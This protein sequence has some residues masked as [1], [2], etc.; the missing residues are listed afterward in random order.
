MMLFSSIDFFYHMHAWTLVVFITLLPFCNNPWRELLLWM[1]YIYCYLLVVPLHRSFSMHGTLLHSTNCL[2]PS[3][4]VS[5]SFS[6][7]MRRYL[8]GKFC[9][10]FRLDKLL[11]KRTIKL[12][13]CSFSCLLNHE[14]MNTNYPFIYFSRSLK[15]NEKDTISS[16]LCCPL[17]SLNNEESSSKYMFNTFLVLVDYLWKR[18]CVEL[19]MKYLLCSDINPDKDTPLESTLSYFH[20]IYNWKDHLALRFS[21]LKINPRKRVIKHSSISLSR[22]SKHESE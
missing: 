18:N 8:F 10:F 13:L 14:N 7:N 6:L 21:G 15:L 9:H 19:T 11:W 20:T 3:L 17:C 2:H 12:T 5:L 16:L 1:D 22:S 4:L